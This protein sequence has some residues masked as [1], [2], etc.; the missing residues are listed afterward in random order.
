MTICGRSS[1]WSLEYP[2]RRNP[3]RVCPSASVISPSS[4]PRSKY[5][6]VDK[7]NSRSTSRLSRLATAKNTASCTFAWVSASTSRSLVR[8]A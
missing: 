1:R 7:K 4:S 3:S 6:D 8:Y 5:V 2:N